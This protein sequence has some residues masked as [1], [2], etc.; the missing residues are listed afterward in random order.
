[1]TRASYRD[2][3]I[4]SANVVQSENAMVVRIA[5]QSRLDRGRTPRTYGP[6]TEAPS[7]SRNQ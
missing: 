3:R 4:A 6:T 5:A 7:R 1:M 2:L